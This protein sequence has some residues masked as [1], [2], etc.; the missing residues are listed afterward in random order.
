MFIFTILY[1]NM[2]CTYSVCA[3]VNYSF[4]FCRAVDVVFYI[5][6]HVEG[7]LVVRGHHLAQKPTILELLGTE[8]TFAVHVEEMLSSIG[9]P[10]YR[11]AIVEVRSTV[12]VTLLCQCVI[13]LIYLSIHPVADGDSCSS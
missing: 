13:S 4:S 8:K 10:E 12:L 3:C 5:L 2:H 6:K 1:I 11:Q 9:M 7:G